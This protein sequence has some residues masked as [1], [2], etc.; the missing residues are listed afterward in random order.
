MS[1]FQY[2]EYE[3]D[4]NKVLKM[5]QDRSLA[6]KNDS[7]MAATRQTADAAIDSSLELLKSLGKGA[8]V[9]KLAQ[10]VAAKGKDRRL[11]HR[12]EAEPWDEIVRQ[13]NEYCPTPVVLEDIMS[14]SE[15]SASFREQ[16]AI[17][18]EFSRQTSLINKTDLSFL[19]IATALQVT[20]ALLFPYVAGKAGY[21]NGFDP[22]NRLA[23]NDKSIERTHRE[24]NDA[25][26][27]KS[28]R[29]TTEKLGIGSIFYT[30]H[31]LMTLHGVHRQRV[32]SCMAVSID[33]IH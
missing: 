1:R 26:K 30:K 18:K 17:N 3:K 27:E 23:H 21:G 9:E 29:K 11:E 22:D 6:L 8:D 13:A 4:L 2:S 19:A 31:R 28:L 33:C 25:F 10:E 15:I 14:E 20:K 12:P 5:N 32:F 24:A 16:D 7:D